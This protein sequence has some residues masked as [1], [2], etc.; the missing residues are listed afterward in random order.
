MNASVAYSPRKVDLFFPCR[1]AQFFSAGAPASDAALCV[2]LARMAYCRSDAGFAFNQGRISTEL[3]RIGFAA[4]AFF[5]SQGTPDG[6]GTH[7]FLAMR[8]DRQLAVVA[9]R[10][11]DK[12]DPTDVA[13]DVDAVPVRW[14]CGGNVHRGFKEALG[15]LAGLEQALQALP[16]RVLFTGHSLGAALA[17]LLASVRAPSAL[18]TFGS[19]LVGDSG[20]VHTLANVRNYRYVDCCDI[21][22][23]LPPEE[24]GY[25][26]VGKPHYIARDGGVTFDPG[27]AF[28]RQDRV[29]AFLEYP[30][31]Y[32][33][34]NA[35]NVGVRELADH[36]PVNYVSAVMAATPPS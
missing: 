2:E 35:A 16:G 18:Y 36:A 9:F 15:R 13:D 27:E 8:Q 12:D 20:F 28:I 34:W 3:A 23:R 19:P 11:T 10:G 21:V 4:T 17:T 14:R 33:A 6:G 29:E 7:C 31:R 32:H 25:R 22:T 26:H 24:L 5:E 1:N 30:T